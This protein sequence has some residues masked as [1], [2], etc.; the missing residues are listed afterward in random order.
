MVRAFQTVHG[1]QIHVARVVLAALTNEFDLFG[2]S[3]WRM[4]PA[5]ANA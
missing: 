2:A 3:R 1:A 5:P 4:P